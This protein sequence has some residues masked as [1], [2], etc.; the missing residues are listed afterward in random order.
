MLHL[1]GN[2]TMAFL[3]LT[4]TRVGFPHRPSDAAPFL[5]KCQA[6]L[7]SHHATSRGRTSC[8]SLGE[9]LVVVAPRIHEVG[10]PRL[11]ALPAHL[12]RL[13]CLPGLRLQY[14]GSNDSKPETFPWQDP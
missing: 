7:R 3:T 5:S 2:V 8:R 6:N 9:G 14:P 4:S 10:P 11:A 13:L 1:S 12:A